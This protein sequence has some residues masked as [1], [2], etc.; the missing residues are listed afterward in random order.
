MTQAAQLQA[1]AD[2][3]A[4]WNP[5]EHPLVTRLVVLRIALNHEFGKPFAEFDHELAQIELAL[6]DALRPPR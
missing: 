2:S 1:D 4:R 5:D 6:A 3:R